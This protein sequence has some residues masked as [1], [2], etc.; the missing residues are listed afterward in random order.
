MNDAD[1]KF[2]C[3]L[4]LGEKSSGSRQ[5]LF[6]IVSNPRNGIDVDKFDY[7][8]RDAQKT[9]V[10][11]VAYDKF[12]LM[13]GARVLNNNEICYPESKDFEVKKL[14]DSRY[15]LYR[16]CYTHRVTQSFEC[17]IIDILN[18]TNGRLYDYLELIEDPEL[19]MQ[20]DDSI[21]QE[22]RM[23]DDPELG[24]ARELLGRF[25]SRQIYSSVG[26]KGLPSERAHLLAEVTE[27]DIVNY[28][29]D[30]GDLKP[31]D[32]WVRTFKIN[33]GMKNQN[34]LEAVSWYRVGEDGQ[35]KYLKK[36]LH[37]ISMMMP[38][39]VETYGIRLF[40][41][42]GSKFEAA[43]NAFRQF[44]KEKLG[45]EPSHERFASHSQYKHQ[46]SQSKMGL[47]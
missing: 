38:K 39:C 33:M 14:F 1:I 22:V 24:K 9:G 45:G 17:L 15:N 29:A 2:I 19:F 36:D 47:S 6:E 44:S 23:S 43:A 16:D 10:G 20:L 35:Y 5:W 11:H 27:K 28:S 18:E 32:I 42:D 12:V 34:P 21:L 8:E 40:V 7:M 46:L 37:E 30:S 25:D 31:E 26:E 13:R 41:K 4:I 3:D